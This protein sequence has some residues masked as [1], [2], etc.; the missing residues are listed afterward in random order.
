MVSVHDSYN[1]D[2]LPGLSALSNLSLRYLASEE[3]ITCKTDS[4]CAVAYLV[5]SDSAAVPVEGWDLPSLAAAGFEAKLGQ[6]M[7]VPST[8]GATTIFVGLGDEDGLDDDAYREAGAAVSGALGKRTQV[9]VVLPEATI[10]TQAQ[11]VVEGVLLANYSLSSFKNEEDRAK[12]LTSLTVAGGEADVTELFEVVLRRAVAY[13]RATYIARDLTNAPPAHLTP[14]TLAEVAVRLADEFGFEAEVIDRLELAE[15]GCGGIVGVNRGSE[16]EARLIKLRFVP[17]ETPASAERLAMVGKGITFDS[18]GLSLKPASSMVD[19]KTD[20]GGAAAILGAFSALVDLGVTTP[21]DAW[22]PTT[23]NM[24][25]GNSMRVGEIITARNGK[26][27]EVTNTDAEGRL[28]L[29]D[30]LALAAET[31]P[32]WIVDIATLTGAQ[33]IALGDDVAAV[34]GNSDALLDEV[35]QAADATG[36]MVWELPLHKR[37][38]KNM[39]SPLADLQNANLSNRGAGS[40]TAGL[41]LSNFVADVPWVHVDIA[42]PSVSSKDDRWVRRGATG[43]GARLL[44][45]LAEEIGA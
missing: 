37:Y 3:D 18:G 42:G 22:L 36:E 2:L 7:T 20:M 33:I 32:A 23:D 12:P 6:T 15:M 45:K 40:I 27:V 38:M 44:A 28:I 16:Y 4:A 35:E 24:I 29:M 19:M 1:I 34:M 10:P 41:F 9:C 39:E 11:A 5:A 8:T 25:S 13:A 26:T 31:N 43:F 21:V 14:R 30:A 17:A